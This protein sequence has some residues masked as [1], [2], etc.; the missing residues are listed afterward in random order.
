MGVGRSGGRNFCL[1]GKRVL[2][3]W[4]VNPQKD[5]R[6]KGQD[7]IPKGNREDL[8]SPYLGLGLVGLRDNGG[9]GLLGPRKEG[10]GTPTPGY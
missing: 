8:C 7:F 4:L 9:L 5:E 3:A 1:Q 10:M 6:I 2:G